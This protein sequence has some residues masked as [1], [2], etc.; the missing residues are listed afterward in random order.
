MPEED[1]ST[2]LE[3]ANYPDILNFRINVTDYLQ[4]LGTCLEQIVLAFEEVDYNEKFDEPAKVLPELNIDEEGHAHINVEEVISGFDLDPNNFRDFDF[5]HNNILLY[6]LGSNANFNI[7][8]LTPMVG[9]NIGAIDMDPEFK[10]NFAIFLGGVEND[11]SVLSSDFKTKQATLEVEINK[12]VLKKK[13]K[14]K[15]LFLIYLFNNIYFRFIY[16]F[17]YLLVCLFICLFI[18]FTILIHYYYY[19]FIIN[20]KNSILK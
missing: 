4:R 15:K 14:K 16:I 2:L 11:D 17:I 5:V 10:L 13:K 20:I 8:K 9:I 7:F 6:V 3:K 12:W 1:Y 19:Y 18:L